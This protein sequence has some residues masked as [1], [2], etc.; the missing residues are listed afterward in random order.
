[1]ILNAPNKTSN[2]AEFV[3]IYGPIKNYGSVFINCIGNNQCSNITILS[4]ET[5][6]INILCQGYRVC[7][8]LKLQGGMNANNIIQCRG[9]QSC[10]YAFF[11]TMKSNLTNITCANSEACIFSSCLSLLFLFFFCVF[12]VN[13]LFF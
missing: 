7:S 11:E 6:N 12:A 4:F 3:K 13:V 1:M 2:E 5:N 8:H 10:K 9:Y